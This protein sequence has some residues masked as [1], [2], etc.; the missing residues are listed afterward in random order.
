ME[1][2]CVAMGLTNQRE[3]RRK[4]F[5]SK[6][7]KIEMSGPNRSHFGILD[8]PGIFGSAIGDLTEE[9]MHGVE[10]MAVS[11]MRK[12]ENIIM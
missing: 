9:D 12:P 2:A 1:Q 11:Y 4:N 6:V 7:L 8:V 5:S 3:G 10:R